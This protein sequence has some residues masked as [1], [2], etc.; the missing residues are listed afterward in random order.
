MPAK[1][2]PNKKEIGEKL[3]T[4]PASEKHTADKQIR[5]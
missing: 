5:D 2:Y 3:P 1:C 4:L